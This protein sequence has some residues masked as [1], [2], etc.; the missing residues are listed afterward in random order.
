MGHGNGRA[1]P[2]RLV[3]WNCADGFQRKRAALEALVPDIAVVA[4]VRRKALTEAELKAGRALWVGDEKGRGLAVL[5]ANGWRLRAGGA[6]ATDRWFMPVVATRRGVT[7]RLLAAWVMPAYDYVTPTQ[8]AL[9]ELG[10]FLS[11]GP[12]LFVGDLNHNIRFDKTRSRVRFRDVIE[13][14]TAC[15]LASAWHTVAGE[16]HGSES[17]GTLYFLWN[18]TRPF[19][20]DY[21]FAPAGWARAVTVGSYADWVATRLSDHVPVTV[22]LV[23]QRA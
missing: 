11:A 14:L 9:A 23:V 12:C 8:R 19:H 7:V 1:T 13:R 4:E 6:P 21:V 18:E 20:I 3:A 22:D 10:D 2:L 17:C 5:A 16:V 15:G